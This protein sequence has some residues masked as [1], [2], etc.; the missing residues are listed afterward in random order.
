MKQKAAT[1]KVAAF[2]VSCFVVPRL[3]STVRQRG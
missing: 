3:C 1:F 2:F